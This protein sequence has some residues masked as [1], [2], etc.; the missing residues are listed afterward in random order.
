[1]QYLKRAIHKKRKILLRS[2]VILLPDKGRPHS[3]AATVGAI[4]QLKFDLLPPP[5]PPHTHT[6]KHNLD[7]DLSEYH[8]SEPVQETSRGR[9][10]AS[11]N[12]VKTANR[13]ENFIC[14]W[15]QKLIHNMS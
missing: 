4:R 15:N 11:G 6:H 10:F 12:E 5:P 14:L 3:V 13:N 1:M 7:L 2:L 9:R 8:M